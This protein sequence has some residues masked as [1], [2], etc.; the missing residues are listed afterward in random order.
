MNRVFWLM[1]L[2]VIVALYSSKCSAVEM[3]ISVGTARYLKSNDTDWWQTGPASQGFKDDFQL[4]APSFSIGTTGTFA[5][6][7]RWHAGYWNGGHIS[8]D[9]WA[10]WRD[11][12]YDPVRKMCVDPSDCKKARFVGTGMVDSV[13]A[14]VG[15]EFN[16]FGLTVEPYA[17]A[18]VY[19]AMFRMITTD[20][21][22]NPY[23]VPTPREQFNI[24]PVIGLAIGKGPISLVADAKKVD[25]SGEYPGF[26]QGWAV[27]TGL[28]YRF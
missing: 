15:R 3:E 19:R 5:D 13:Y 14:T 11:W 24:G 23:I 2:A 20:D 12:L 7:Y 25:R 16:V 22:G 4:S 27:F 6:S 10:T 9:A 1:L 21:C 17:G 28:R 18:H 26:W 8:S